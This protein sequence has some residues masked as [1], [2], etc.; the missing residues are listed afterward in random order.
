[1]RGQL[2]SPPIAASRL[3][4]LRLKLRR[5]M[6]AEGMGIH[7]RRKQGQSLE[8]REHRSYQMGDDIRSVDWL[9][10]ARRYGSGPDDLLVRAFEAE[11]KMLVAVVLDLRPAM[12]LP[13]AAPKLLFALW[14]AQSLVRNAA[15]AGDEVVLGTLF[16]PEDLRPQRLRGARAVAAAA[17]LAARAWQARGGHPETL[18]PVRPERLI[19]ALKPAAAVVL[20]SDMLFEDPEGKVEALALAA[21]RSRRELL[22]MELDSFAAEA[23]A[24]ALNGPVVL[25]PFEGRSFAPTPGRF[26][27]P[28]FDAARQAMRTFLAERRRL[29][30]R[31]GL[32]WPEAVEWPAG[33]G[34]EDLATL[35][36]LR[37]AAHPV[38]RALVGQGSSG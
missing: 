5:T 6:P 20:I 14:A 37:F 22:V 28:E 16:G 23:A 27:Q 12:A 30:R 1:M 19:R 36:R 26:G 35:F 32:F 38:L 29:W 2:L 18:P 33:S 25:A 13:E 9:A 15:E 11:E 24:P 10:S 3:R 21:Q 34:T 8:F 4:Q 17:A 31:G 7:L